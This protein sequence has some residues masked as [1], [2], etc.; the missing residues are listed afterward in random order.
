MIR[1]LATAMILFAF[2]TPGFSEDAH[3]AI[4]KSVAGHVDIFRHAQTIPASPGM[5]L[6]QADKIISGDASSVGIIFIDGT[7]ITVGASSE[8]EI[9]QYLFAPRKSEYAF[10]L[11]IRR[12]ETIYSSGQLGKLAAEKVKLNTPRATVGVRGTRFIVKVED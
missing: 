7:R 4:I 6:A 1:I 9:R 2:T 10:S 11:Y 12:G 5:Q 3:V 8:V